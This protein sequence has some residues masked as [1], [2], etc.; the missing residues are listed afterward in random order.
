[1]DATM[2]VSD[3]PPPCMPRIPP[4]SRHDIRIPPYLYEVRAHD[5][6]H[7]L[8]ESNYAQ[9]IMFWD[10]LFGSYVPYNDQFGSAEGKGGA[11][12][13]GEREKEKEKE[14]EKSR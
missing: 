6:H 5:V 2:A 12:G 11:D 3:S 9:Y 8:P 4:H 13:S 7:R 14:K 1:M 10:R